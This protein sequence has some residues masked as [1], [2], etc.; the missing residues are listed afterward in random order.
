LRAESDFSVDVA[1]LLSA[2][3]ENTKLIFLCSP[4]NPVGTVIPRELILQIVRARSGKSVVIIDEAYVEYGDTD[5]LTP[6]VRE[7]D[8]LVVLRTLSKALALAGAR[9][10]AVVASAGLIR[11]LDGVLAPYA[12]SSPVISSA[13]Q[14]LSG[15][16]LT[17]AKELVNGIIAERERLR[18]ELATCKAVQFIW[19]SKANFL[20]IR[21][22]NLQRVGR[23]LEKAG[24]AIRTF[25]ADATLDNCARITVAS[26]T[27]ND[28]LIAAIRSL[29]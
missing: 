26:K 13:E 25:A 9:C 23:C 28:R 3:D 2:C 19:P 14:A 8:N 10:G 7:F 27:D 15:A 5:S 21:F 29:D 20:L 4:N 11:L 18:S 12:V 1:A 22:E 6:L 17:E 24:I 16:Q